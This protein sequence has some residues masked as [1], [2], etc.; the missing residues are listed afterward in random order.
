M[1]ISTLIAVVLICASIALAVGVSKTLYDAVQVAPSSSIA[2]FSPLSS[3]VGGKN[4]DL[5]SAV[6]IGGIVLTFLASLLTA[7]LT[8]VNV[9]V[10]SRLARDLEHLKPLLTEQFHAYS[11]LNQA[12]WTLYEALSKMQSGNYDSTEGLGADRK[13]AESEGKSFFLGHEYLQAWKKFAYWG[14]FARESADA[15]LQ[16]ISTNQLPYKY[17]IPKRGWRYWKGVPATANSQQ[18]LWEKLQASV[19]TA[20]ED[21]RKQTPHS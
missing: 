2:T 10:Q 20:L 13:I 3:L 6:K 14:N 9:F 4:L 7:C 11:D 1:R 19:Y 8:V 21:L 18:E 16:A 15:L 17:K 12:A 5:D